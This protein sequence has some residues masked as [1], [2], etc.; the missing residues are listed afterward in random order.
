MDFLFTGHDGDRSLLQVSPELH[1]PGTRQRELKAL[2][3]AMQ[4]CKLRQAT[5][6]TT[7][8]EEKL[9]TEAG[10]IRILPAWL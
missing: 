7:N 4:E 1:E 9:E 5:V 3:E 8:D 2:T 10:Q 6:V